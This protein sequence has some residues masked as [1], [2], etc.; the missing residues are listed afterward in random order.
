M[1]SR[2]E[3]EQ[4][5]ELTAN[6]NHYGGPPPLDGIIVKL[7]AREVAIAQLESGEVDLVAA[8]PVGELERLEENPNI[9]IHSVESPSITQIAVNTSQPYLADKRVRQA[10]MCAIDRQGIIDSVYRGQATVVNSPIIGP[11]TWMGQPEFDTYAFDPDRARGLLA[12]AGWDSNQPV[13]M[14]YASGADQQMETYQAIIQQQLRDVGV[15]L[16]LRAY[17]IAEI[18][19]RRM[20]QNDDGTFFGEYDLYSY[21]GGVYRADPSNAAQYFLSEIAGNP[22]IQYYA[23]PDI[24]ALF[25]A[26]VQ[27]IDLEERKAIY[28]DI[29]R[30]LNDEVPVLFLW[31]PNSIYAASPRLQ[32]FVPPTY[33]SA[34]LW[35]AET[36][37]IA[38]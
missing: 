20:Q 2:W 19:R 35:N 11:P 29:A 4:F 33:A 38:G 17:D 36:W 27:T 28:T 18:R 8:I 6:A 9:V 5:V 15:N 30:I 13:E 1:F 3:P 16:E 12:E 21:G 10:F 23:N 14:M 34:Y 24:D 26:G 31:S 22:N 32:G 37:T 7:L 25:A